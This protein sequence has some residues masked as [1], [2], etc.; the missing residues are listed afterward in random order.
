LAAIIEGKK[1]PVQYWEITE[2]V[3]EE[4]RI[5]CWRPIQQRGDFIFHLLGTVVHTHRNA[6]SLYQNLRHNYAI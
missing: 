1:L 6:I 4:L 2:M 5:H 3:S